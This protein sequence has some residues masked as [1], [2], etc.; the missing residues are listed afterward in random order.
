MQ[1]LNI[2]FFV[3]LLVQNNMQFLLLLYF[4]VRNDAIILTYCYRSRI[5]QIKKII[6]T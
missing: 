2:G 6:L 4:L 5:E 1:A 3:P